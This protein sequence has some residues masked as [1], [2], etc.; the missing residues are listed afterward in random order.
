MT[1]AISAKSGASAPYLCLL[2][3]CSILGGNDSGEGLLL[4]VLAT[5]VTEHLGSAW[6]VRDST[7]LGHHLSSRA[8]WV[9]TIIPERL[10]GARVHLL[11]ANNHDTVCATM[12]N[13][14]SRQVKPSRSSRAVIVNVIDW[15][16]G[17]AE[18][19]EDALAAGGVAVAVAGHALVDI[20]VVDLGVQEC[21]DSGLEAELGVVD[22][23]AWLDELGHAD[24]EDV[25]GLGW[26][27]N[28]F[29][30]VVSIFPNCSSVMSF[31]SR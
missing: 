23:S 8:S 25:A 11:K 1:R 21:L 30:G 4:H 10:Q 14:I 26:G 3:S 17:H 24:A 9:L 28:H 13:D 6:C 18:L 20:V 19:I 15:D 22:L 7:S 31:D 27:L 12:A 5:S 29:G 16:L 2:V